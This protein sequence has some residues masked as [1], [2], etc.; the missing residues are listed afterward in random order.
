MCKV[1]KA[2]DAARSEM[3]ISDSVELKK[4]EL[5]GLLQIWKVVNVKE[6]K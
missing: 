2:C 5:D 3:V 1:N 4:E 6:R